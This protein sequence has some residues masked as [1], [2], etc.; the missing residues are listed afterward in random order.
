MAKQRSSF[1]TKLKDLAAA[2][3]KQ[4]TE[5]ENESDTWL[6]DGQ[7]DGQLAIDVYQTGKDIIIK[8]TIA[9]V[10]PEDIDISINND[11]VTIKGMRRQDDTVSDEDFI[12]RECYWGGFSRSVILPVDIK[13]G[14]VK[15][16]L[17]NGVLTIVLPKAGTSKVQTIEV[18][19]LDDEA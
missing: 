8:S 3:E 13:E 17:K 12:Y 6:S 14:R 15:A 7:F 18:E 10:K 16:S 11:M 9:G 5:A 1:V 19:N 2:E 4:P